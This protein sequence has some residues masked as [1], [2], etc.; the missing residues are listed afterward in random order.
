M[1]LFKRYHFECGRLVYTL[2]SIKQHHSCVNSLES[3]IYT[4]EESK[5]A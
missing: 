4:S 2:G 1:A 3:K 5:L